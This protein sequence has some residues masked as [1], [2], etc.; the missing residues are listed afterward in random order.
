MKGTNSCPPFHGMSLDMRIFPV[1]LTCLSL[2]E[3][4][5]YVL[6]PD[7]QYFL[8]PI[9]MANIF[10]SASARYAEHALEILTGS[11]SQF[12][13]LNTRL[14]GDQGDKCRMVRS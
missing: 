8:R 1:I 13:G 11:Y 7:K 9:P 12:G 4:V 3:A 2:L 6:Y 10:T 5:A 14:G